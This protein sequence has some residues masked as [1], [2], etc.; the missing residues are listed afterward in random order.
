ML[1]NLKMSAVPQGL[2]M[3]AQAVAMATNMR[4]TSGRY[5]RV[6]LNSLPRSGVIVAA[7]HARGAAPDSPETTLSRVL[8]EVNA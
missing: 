5:V 6:L 4:T 1:V 7:T 8:T 3:A 2:R